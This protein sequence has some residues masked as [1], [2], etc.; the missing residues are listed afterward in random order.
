MS[1][2]VE[3]EGSPI[4]TQTLAGK[5]LTPGPHGIQ[6]IGAGFIPATLDLKMV[7]RIERAG[8][9]ESIEMSRRLAREEGILSGISCGAAVA[10]AVRVAKEPEMK[11]KTI[12]VILPDSGER[13]LTS[14]LFDG[15]GE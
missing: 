10:V 5:P 11:G 9:D 14:V 12:V 8:D 4:I 1:I 13:Y 3:P 2:G 7:D 6:G 15:V